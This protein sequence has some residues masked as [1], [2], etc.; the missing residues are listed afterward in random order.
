MKLN[1][2]PRGWQKEA[3]PLWLKNMSGVV[4]VVTGGGKTFFAFLAIQEVLKKYD[5]IHFVIIV[6]T[7]AL[8]DQWYIGLIDD[9]GTNENNISCF[10]GKEKPKK[11]NLINIIII[12]TARKKEIRNLFLNSPTMLIVDECHRSGSIE[13]AKALNFSQIASLGLSAT[14]IRDYDNGFN[15]LI[16]PKIGDIIYEYDYNKAY[17]DGVIC[18]FNL[19]NIKTYFLEEE[20]IEYNKISKRISILIGKIKKGLEKYD[21]L[22]KLLIQRSRV[23]SNSVNRVIACLKL[24]STNP[25]KQTII[26]CE[27]I[28]HANTIYDYLKANK[29]MAGVYHSKIRPDIRRLNLKLYKR[30]VNKILI[31]CKALDEGLNAPNTDMAIIVS[32]TKSKR[33]R[34]QRLGRVLRTSDDKKKSIIYTIYITKEEQS[35]L[36][37]EYDKLK[38]IT[39]VSW[40]KIGNASKNI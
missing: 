5:N 26:F 30:G 40:K 19:I 7:E 3:L 9:M 34:V 10:S 2:K 15:E 37:R 6:P 16:K 31:T 12:N 4:S 28:L 21:K 11:A 27:S 24:I 39:S 29:F 22:E 23:S 14:P 38:E 36:E 20:G 18:D 1:F 17:A 13:N 33:Q 35:I 25:N 8:L 32:S